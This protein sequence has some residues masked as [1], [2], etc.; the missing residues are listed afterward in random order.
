MNAAVR[1]DHAPFGREITTR[2]R[3]SH[4]R[5]GA[6]QVF[7]MHEFR[8]GRIITAEAAGRKAG[9]GLY[10]FRPD[11]DIGPNVPLEAANPGRLLSEFQ[12]LLIL[13][14]R[15]PS[16]L[17]FINIYAEAD[18]SNNLAAGVADR[19]RAHAHPTLPTP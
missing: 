10:L 11:T 1:P 15:F 7:G 9:N 12:A 8:P 13:T 17:L 14:E 6:R 18:A 19:R 4:V 3:G 2:E 5:F 16:L